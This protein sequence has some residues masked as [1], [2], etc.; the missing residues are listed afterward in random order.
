MP[1][2]SLA[3]ITEWLG[4]LPA[5]TNG[6]TAGLTA[7][8]E[9]RSVLRARGIAADTSAI[10]AALVDARQRLLREETLLDAGVSPVADPTLPPD[11]PEA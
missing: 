5:L 7:F 3:L 1:Q 9:I 11:G 2:I 10:D 8:E 4:Y 6:T